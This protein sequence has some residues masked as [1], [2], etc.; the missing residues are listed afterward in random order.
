MPKIKLT[1]DPRPLNGNP[2]MTIG[3]ARPR[4]RDPDKIPGKNGEWLMAMIDT[5]AGMSQI[6]RALALKIGLLVVG[7]AEMVTSCGSTFC[8]GFLGDVYLPT[9]ADPTT[10]IPG[11]KNCSVVPDVKLLE[12]KYPVLG[13]D[14][15]IGMDILGLGDLQIHG[16][17]RR[18]GT[19]SWKNERTQW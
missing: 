2:L 4:S 18:R 13:I 5:G 11:P 16:P 15:I 9:L 7:Q 14:G 12:L 3:V 17:A 10:D 19:F 1:F 6:T 8:D